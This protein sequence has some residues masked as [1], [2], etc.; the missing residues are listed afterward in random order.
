[1]AVAEALRDLGHRV[2]FAGDGRYVR[3]AGS[4][5]APRGFETLP[6][7]DLAPEEVLIGSFDIHTRESAA[8]FVQAERA[9]YR[10]I[11]PDA[12]IH[13][14]RPT[15]PVSAALAGIPSFAVNNTDYTNY[16]ARVLKAP[17][18][19]P[20]AKTFRR[21]L[22]ARLG[23][24]VADRVAPAAAR[25]L[26]RKAARPHNALLRSH[27]QP[28]R[29]NILAVL[30]GSALN[31]L[32]DAREWTPVRPLPANFLF[33]G[34]ILWSPREERERWERVRAALPSGRPVIYVTF[35]ST[36]RREVFDLVFSE[37]GGRDEVV[38]LTTGGQVPP[39]VAAPANFIVE[40]F[41]PGEAVLEVAELMVCHG[42]SG[43]L[44]QAALAGRPVVAVAMRGDQ[45]WNGEE[46]VRLGIGRA[47][48]ARAVLATPGSLY[49][50]VREILGDAPLRDGARRLQQILCAYGGP[51]RAAEAMTEWLA[52]R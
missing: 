18:D 31:F 29:E 45:E 13:D 22:G 21:L 25:M 24:A 10:E 33:V 32:A 52:R 42:G 1:V 9:L 30:E 40:E 44:Y 12:V 48:T 43:S 19:H 35:G 36:G 15:A 49:G 27:G 8:R 37:L 4:V 3:G 41:L 5:V 7:A 47:T 17:V 23:Q 51:R 2:V 26:F 39:G 11:R 28:A 46:V 38:I 16:S 6:L 50:L 20:V 14:Y 34:P